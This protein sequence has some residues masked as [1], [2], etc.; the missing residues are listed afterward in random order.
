VLYIHTHVTENNISLYGF[1]DQNELELFELLL[2]VSGIG[3]KSAL[4]IINFGVEKI[5]QAIVQAEV[6]FFTQIPRLGTKNAQKIIIELKNKLGSSID[7]DLTQDENQK[8]MI[9]VLS[10]MGFSRQEA[11]LAIKQI[12]GDIATLEEKIRYALK[13][14]SK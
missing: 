10:G 1:G 5:K 13:N 7:L 14:L 8:E 4:G 3:P 11:I 6:N 9:T 2:T 12:P